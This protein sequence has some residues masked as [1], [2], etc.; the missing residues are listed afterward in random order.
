MSIL[1]NPEVISEKV[2]GIIEIGE[3]SKKLSLDFRFMFSN[4]LNLGDSFEWDD[5]CAGT[6]DKN[7]LDEARSAL[8]EENE[9]EESQAGLKEKKVLKYDAYICCTYDRND[10]K[11]K[12]AALGLTCEKEYFFAE[13]FFYLLDDL[14]GSRIAFKSYPGSFKGWLKA[15]VFGFAAKHGIMVPPEKYVDLLNGYYNGIDGNPS[16]KQ[17]LQENLLYQRI[18]YA[19]YAVPG[20]LETLPQIFAKKNAYKK[21]DYICFHAVSD[22]IR[23]K[24][25]FPELKEKIITVEELRAHTMASLYMRAVYFDTRQNSCACDT[26]YN[27]MWI[28]K[29]GTARLCECPD[30]LDLSCGNVGAANPTE[31]WNSPLAKIIRLSIRNNSYT[32]CSRNLCAKLSEEKEQKTLLKRREIRENDSPFN[33]NI[34]NDYVCN[35]HC[36]SCRKGIYA[37]NDE[38]AELEIETCTNAILAAGWLDRA[39]KLLVGGGGETFLSKNYKRVLYDGEVKRNSVI[40]MT[41]GTLFT[42]DE[43]KHLEGKYEQIGFM[44]SVDAATKETYEKVRCGGNFERLMKN[45]DFLSM[46]RKEKKVDDVKVILIV[47]RANYREIPDFIRWA[48]EKGFDAVNLSHI[49]NWGSF[50]DRDFYDHVSMF[51]RNGNMNSELAEILKDPVCADPIVHMSWKE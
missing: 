18:I 28:G 12:M 25:D 10:A 3:G 26:P 35:L 37:K 34:A 50:K 48:K 42:P 15:I 24:T 17:L 9:R 22:A 38:N 4:R 11:K 2:Y 29:S 32:F 19:I 30:F 40:I 8:E 36:P 33:I 44:V 41:N 1:K 5:F 27:T 47:Q 16:R 13:D 21:Y 20:I 7:E 6:G 49:R 46:L 23:F 31:V 51:D 14:K 43:W 39:G 45:M